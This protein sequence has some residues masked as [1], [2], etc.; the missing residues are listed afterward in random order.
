MNE[1]GTIIYDLVEGVARVYFLVSVGLGVFYISYRLLMGP[2]LA[3]NFLVEHRTAVNEWLFGDEKHKKDAAAREE[4]R[5]VA[6]VANDAPEAAEAA[7]AAAK[8]ELYD[9]P[10]G[11]AGAPKDAGIESSTLSTQQN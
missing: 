2:I 8:I 5:A 10:R 4:P 11:R 9:E 1:I 3:F 6:V 7:A